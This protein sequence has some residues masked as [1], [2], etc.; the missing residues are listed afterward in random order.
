MKKIIITTILAFAAIA[1]YAQAPVKPTDKPVTFSQQQT[2]DI[3]KALSNTY[4]L[5][6]KL[7]IKA[8]QRDT[9]DA[10]IIAIINFM[11]AKLDTVK[12]GLTPKIEPKKP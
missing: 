9:I 8:K 3:I 5:I 4:V 2:D 6:H 12:L 1:S 10:P 7:D 11:G